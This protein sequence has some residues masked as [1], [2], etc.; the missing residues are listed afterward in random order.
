MDF[1]D[2]R[3]LGILALVDIATFSCFNHHVRLLVFEDFRD[4]LCEFF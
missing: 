3:L 2:L 4:P 1:V